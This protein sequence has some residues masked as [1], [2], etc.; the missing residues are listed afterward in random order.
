[1]SA[2]E[3]GLI[4]S[5][6]LHEYSEPVPSYAIKL[7]KL[8]NGTVNYEVS[9]KNAKDDAELDLM[10]LRAIAVAQVSAELLEKDLK[11]KKE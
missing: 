7:S 6:V 11:K 4:T 8:S 1:M 5:K 9:V 3:D 2:G 10:L